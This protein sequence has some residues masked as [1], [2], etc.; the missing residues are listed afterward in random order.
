[1][2]WLR[3]YEDED[4]SWIFS[5]PRLAEL[6][7]CVS[8]A[9][10]LAQSA[11]VKERVAFT[12]AGL[13]VTETF[14]DFCAARQQVSRIARPGANAAELFAAWKNYRV[15][16]SRFEQTF[17]DTRRQWPLAIA[18]PQ[19]LELYLRN[20]PDSRIARELARTPA[21]RALLPSAA[22]FVS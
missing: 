21:G 2:L 5:T 14:S 9:G 11:I 13:G 7:R 15:A 20:E 22:D 17:A 3:Y 19:A 18:K 16:R 12:S 6:R 4:Q 1:P 10:N 8:E